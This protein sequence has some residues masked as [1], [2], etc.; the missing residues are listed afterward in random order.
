MDDPTDAPIYFDT[1][2]PDSPPGN[3]PGGN[4]QDIFT[5]TG[6]TPDDSSPNPKVEL[7]FKP[8]VSVKGINDVNFTVE[9]VR[10][11]NVKLVDENGNVVKEEVRN[12]FTYFFH[13]AF[14]LYSWFV[15]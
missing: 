8:E 1:T 13:S 3:P 11:V 2:S 14:A 9:N 6:F 7:E 15:F 10:E 12:Q 5:P 4:P